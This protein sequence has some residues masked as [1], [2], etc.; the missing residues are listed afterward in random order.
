MRNILVISLLFLSFFSYSQQIPYKKYT[1]DDGLAQSQVISLILDEKQQVW[2]GTNGGGVSVYDGFNFKNYTI[3]NGLS[4]NFIYSLHKDYKNN[5]WIGT[6]YGVTVY[7]NN[8]FTKIIN[9]FK[10]G[11][12]IYT[13]AETKK[14]QILIGTDAGIKIYKNGNF[15]KIITKSKL[16]SSVVYKI[17]EDANQN[18]WV[19]TQENGLFKYNWK[20]I[21]QYTTSNG[22]PYNTVRVLI[23]DKNKNLIIGT[24]L[25]ACFMDKNGVFHNQTNN[26]QQGVTRQTYTDCLIANDSNVILINYN[27]WLSV[28]NT[29]NNQINMKTS[30]MFP[31]NAFRKIVQDKEGTIWIGLMTGLI[32]FDGT[33]KFLNYY[34]SQ[35]P[36]MGVNSYAVFENEKNVYISD[37]QKGIIVSPKT[38]NVK[39]LKKDSIYD[40]F[41]FIKDSRIFSIIEDYDK[42]LWFSTWSGI[43]K[44]LPSEN[45]SINYSNNTE[46]NKLN[47]KYSSL[48][49][50]DST[51]SKTVNTSVL[52]P[53]SSIWFGTL[54]GIIIYKNKTFSLLANQKKEFELLKNTEIIKLLIDKDNVIWATTKNG[55]LKITNNEITQYKEK[56]GFVDTQVNNIEQD[57]KGNF[58]FSTRDGLFFYNNKKFTNISK[59]HNLNF[60][61]IY[62]L[63]IDKYNFLYIGTNNG[64]D[65]FN[66]NKFYTNNKI[67][68]KHYGKE[69]GF[70]G[71][72]CNRNASFKDKNGNLWFGTVNGVVKYFP[73]RDQQKNVEPNTFIT[74]VEL[75]L[76]KDSIELFGKGTNENGLINNLKLSYNKTHLTFHFVSTSKKNSTKVKFQYKLIPLNEEWMPVTSNFADFPILPNGNY[77]IMVRSC[78]DEGTWDSTPAQYSFSVEPPFWKTLWFIITFIVTII[79]LVILFIKYREKKLIKEKQELEEKVTE[80]TKEV[81]KQ[82]EIVEQ[83]NKDITDSINY[84][85]NIQQALLPG[86]EEFRRNFEN[87]LIVYKPR[88]IVSGDFYWLTSKNN[89]TYVTAADCTGH[90]V[91]GAFMSMLGMAFLDQIVNRSEQL[92]AAQILNK[93]RQNVIHSLKQGP[94]SKSRDGMDMGLSIIDW[95]NKKFHFAGANNS[96]YLIS[97]DKI[98]TESSE[99]GN[100]ELLPNLECENGYN[101]FEIKPD[102]MPIGYFIK[103]DEF[104]NHIINY[105]N[106]DTIFMFSDGYADQF[107]GKEGKKFKYI[108]FKKLFLSIANLTINEQQKIIDNTFVD[109]RK[110]YEQLD[111]IIVVGI[112]L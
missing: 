65:K 15:E 104:T 3:E 105:N 87:S 33:L 49:K 84:A 56:D 76:G 40:S 86:E 90:G 4:S 97:T 62:I 63:E 101:L 21:K 28:G 108:K 80:R 34:Q 38:Q 99:N 88:D 23:Q 29:D 92:N 60:E 82:K 5:I 24:D 11:E 17:F 31:E 94:S 54:Q 13:I 109:W 7:K 46:M 58:W 89:K 70:L 53:D 107:G 75:N 64:I 79:I 30:I 32:K 78:N 35:I 91:P 52:L 61:A 102:K 44:F 10:D 22:L 8:K 96:L 95:E 106:G 50:L 26:N 19:G 100:T 66:L 6:N 71:V 59:K 18:I 41:N 16:D 111:D 81:V 69:D 57:F 20:T 74:N 85:R 73:D 37:Y 42:N 67:I 47:K 48:V 14:G 83:K 110:G 51:F 77:T 98:K 112:K 45:K 93:M 39:P 55:I 1:I 9:G 103:N 27:G 2:A 72:E 68:L 43:T 25:T 12:N 36:S